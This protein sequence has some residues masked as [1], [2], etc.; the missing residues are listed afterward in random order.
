MR[1]F[2]AL[3]VHEINQRKA[4]L[5]A[6][7]VAS[8]LPLAAPLLPATGSNPAED[9]REA[10]LWVMVGGLVPLFALLLGVSF[11]GRDLA[12]GRLGFYYA[13]PLSG[14]TIWFGKLGAVL[15]LI[16]A[17][18]LIIMLPTASL[19]SDPLR[20]FVLPNVLESAV[21]K[22][23]APVLSFVAAAAV[24]LVAHAVGIIWRARSAWLIVD[25][26]ALVAVIGLGWLAISPFLPLVAPE[27]ITVAGCWMFAWFLVALTAAG[28]VQATFGRVD[29]GRCH[30]VVSMTLWGVLT[31]SVSAL[32][33]W[34]L[35]VRSADI[36]DLDRALV[37]ATGPGDWI[38]VGGTSWGRLD[39][40][41]RFL[42]NVVE[43]RTLPIGPAFNWSG[44]DAML[45]EG[46]SAALWLEPEGLLSW[47]VMT[48][49]LAAE[50]PLALPTGVTVG[51]EWEDVAIAPDGTRFA[52]LEGRTLAVYQGQPVQQ[53]TAVRIEE[54]LNPVAI[55]FDDRDRVRVLAS[56]R[57]EGPIGDTRWWLLWLEVADRR[58]GDRVE[59]DWPWR[60]GRR[61]RDGRADHSLTQ[62]RYGGTTHVAIRDAESG[63]LLRDLEVRSVWHVR[64]LEDGG[65]LV[66][67]DRDED[68]R[69]EL[70]GANGEP[71]WT[72]DLPEAG[73]IFG[74]LIGAPNLMLLGVIGFESD[75][76]ERT[77]R[78]CTLGLDLATGSWRELADGK[79][80]VLGRWGV[81][82]SM[83]SWAVGSIASRL[84]VDEDGIVFLWDPDTGGI[85]QVVPVVP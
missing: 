52:V 65:V 54:E 3:V 34:S 82:S 63:E 21:P 67:R 25:T 57:Q 20:F 49:D 61:S 18:E 42:V 29:P 41:P 69:A 22:W 1:G 62:I 48:A 81:S 39:Y 84:L 46:G 77:A 31:V 70:Y 28:A 38:V 6:A 36:E 35:W 58:L 10:V 72:A 33:A 7:A 11:I 43:G 14:P 40:N 8:L 13:Q 24:V 47:A 37:V 16:W 85:R 9:I 75:A 12:E 71:V 66:I 68:N 73:E 80:P 59:I 5:A 83:G 55:L 19:S 32:L 60:W 4:L 45:A 26:L 64:P 17:V 27:I 2:L 30:R 44:Q 15:L 50:R 74:G 79:I 56:S 53:L 76:G 78:F 23:L 51:E